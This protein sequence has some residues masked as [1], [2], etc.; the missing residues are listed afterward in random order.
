M[1][2]VQ[3]KATTPTPEDD[4]VTLEKN[5]TPELT[6]EEEFAALLKRS[7]GRTYTVTYLTR[8]PLGSGTLTVYQQGKST[9]VDVLTHAK[10]LTFE[11][12]Q[13]TL[14]DGMIFCGKNETWHCLKVPPP[15]GNAT[16]PTLP[17]QTANLSFQNLTPPR[18]VRSGQ[19]TLLNFKL[20]CFTSS[21]PNVTTEQCFTKD[22]ILLYLDSRI[23]VGEVTWQATDY[24]P[25]VPPGVFTPP[26]TPE[27]MPEVIPE[28]TTPPTP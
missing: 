20:Q 18:L 19:R 22:G 23:P 26:A 5:A 2:Q 14:P 28:F 27:A 13:Y 25:R 3:H 17:D 11:S 8:D 9:R 21:L 10:G 4:S 7:E 12:R 1:V 15:T 16:L 24:E 6:P